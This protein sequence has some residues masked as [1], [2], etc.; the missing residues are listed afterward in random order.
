MMER[1]VGKLFICFVNA[2][3][4]YYVVNCVSEDQVRHWQGF[5]SKMNVAKKNGTSLLQWITCV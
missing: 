4:G 5:A 1:L 3:R 2:C